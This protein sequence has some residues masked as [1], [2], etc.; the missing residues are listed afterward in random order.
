MSLS[1]CLCV[2]VCVCVCVCLQSHRL[3]EAHWDG[4]CGLG[5]EQQ[6]AYMLRNL[7]Q[8]SCAELAQAIQDL[9]T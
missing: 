5:L 1:V 3:H 9:H 7:V 2:C 4:R 6:A 8:P